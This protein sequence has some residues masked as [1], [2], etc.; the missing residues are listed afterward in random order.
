MMISVKVL[1]K[2]SVFVK[3]KFCPRCISR[4]LGTVIRRSCSQLFF[5]ICILN[6]FVIF[7][8]KCL[9]CSLFIKVA[10]HDKFFKTFNPEA[11]LG[12]L[13]HPRWS[14]L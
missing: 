11:D 8:E 7:T 4:R 5:K 2:K 12:L 13:Q 6:K 1:A 3:K 14:A 10:S 9:C